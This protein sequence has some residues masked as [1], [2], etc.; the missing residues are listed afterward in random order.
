MV[1][2]WIPGL[3]VLGTLRARVVHEELYSY[4]DL[5]GTHSHIPYITCICGTAATSSRSTPHASCRQAIRHV[6]PKP[7]Q[8][9]GICFEIL[10]LDSRN[11]VNTTS[12]GIPQENQGTPHGCCRRTVNVPA[13]R[14]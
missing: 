1:F 6:G 2:R 5:H 9:H 4:L 3:W 8:A 11:L 12:V 10:L 13:G 7:K 14:V